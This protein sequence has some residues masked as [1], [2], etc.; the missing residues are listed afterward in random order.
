MV[1]WIFFDVGNVILND[2]PVMAEIYRQLHGFIIEKN[3]SVTMDQLLAEREH[4][5]LNDRDCRQHITLMKKYLNGD[6]Y[7]KY[8]IIWED[9]GRRWSELSPLMTGVVP[10]LEQ[11]HRDYKLGLIANQPRQVVG[12]LDDYKIS[13]YFSVKAL[14]EIAGMKKPDIRFFKYALL[15]AHCSPDEAVMIGDR[16]D[17]DIS[18]AKSIGM[19]TIWLKLSIDSKGFIPATD[20]EA[21]FLKSLTRASTNHLEPRFE[22]ETPDYIAGSFEDIVSDIK[23]I[24]LEE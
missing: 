9:L 6:G 17:Y 4:L 18:P 22:S 2:D 8:N 15:N 24:D 19:R 10:V 3:K 5:L 21:K 7:S 20:H 13:H 12:V 14:S 1:K 23:M 11:L 16:I